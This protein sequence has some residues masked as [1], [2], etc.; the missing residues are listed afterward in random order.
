MG[1]PLYFH[2]ITKS[3]KNIITSYKQ[4]C[5][6][7][8]LD[9]NGIIHN[10]FQNIKKE[11]NNHETTK[12]DFE[13]ELMNKV[14]EYMEI[15]CTFVHPKR[16]M[17]ICIDGVAPLP[18]I[19]QQRKRRYLSVWLKSQIKEEGYHWDSNAISPGTTFMKKL[20]MKLRNYIKTKNCSYETVLSDSSSPGEGEHKIFDYIHFH[21]DSSYIDVIY[22]LDADLIMLSLICNKSQKFLLREPQHYSKHSSN[23]STTSSPFLWFNIEKLKTC[24]N[25]YYEYKI[26]VHSYAFLCFMIG[27]D[28]LPNL[29]YLNIQN[30]GIDKI[31]N[32]Y[33]KIINNSFSN[34]TIIYLNNQDRYVIN[35]DM[36][37]KLIEELMVYEDKEMKQLH[38]N[39]Y[40]KSMI[41][42]SHKMKLENYGVS[43]KNNVTKDMF[44]SQNWRFYYYTHLADM[45]SYCDKT[46]NNMSDS[47]VK[48]LVWVSNYY[49]NKTNVSNWYYTTEYSPTLL[50]LYNYL[51]VS[52]NELQ[53][54]E[55]S[56]E[57][58]IDVHSDLQLLLILPIQSKDCLPDEVSDLMSEESEIG[59][60]Y[61][62][63]FKIQSYLKTKL[64]ECHPI[65]PSIDIETIQTVYLKTIS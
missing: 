53:K 12:D 7:L 15:V 5:D 9:F 34:E 44:E 36:F 60:Y 14:I 52:K 45:N 38:S 17:Y 64:H 51:E 54:Q 65:L 3:H 28:F 4:K 32:A 50:D 47:Y 16:L 8:F 35:W 55:N 1:I 25:S 30:E 57:P 24:L 43:Y 20:N 42:K 29:T 62:I 23:D 41:F 6:R 46:I 19:Q 11:Y 26:D 21:P 31:F 18:K 56:C 49:F 37:T 59:F 13:E 40:N 33:L 63:N 48:G 27:N 61:P 2:K 22:G 10:V 39:Y 58:L